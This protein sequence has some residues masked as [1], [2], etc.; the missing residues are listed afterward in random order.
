MAETI[1]SNAKAKLAAGVILLAL[2][3]VPAPLLPP[4][5]LAEVVQSVLGVGWKAAYLVA[6]VGLQIGFYRGVGSQRYRQVAGDIEARLDR[7]PAL[8]VQ[9]PVP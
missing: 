1:S 7:C 9:K 4:H 6:A 3:I 2:L 8:T 5:R